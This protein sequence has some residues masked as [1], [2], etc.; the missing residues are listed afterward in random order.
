MFCATS[1]Y[2][3]HN[4]DLG[5]GCGVTLRVRTTKRYDT[6]AE[7]ATDRT[8]HTREEGRKGKKENATVW[9]VRKRSMRRHVD[10]GGGG[11]LRGEQECVRDKGQGRNLDP[12]EKPKTGLT[13]SLYHLKLDYTGPWTLSYGQIKLP[14]DSWLFFNVINRVKHKYLLVSMPVKFVTLSA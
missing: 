11:G 2:L 3:C 4:W 9:V 6:I 1:V 7:G 14:D 8:K 10:R 5:S 12:Q 13:L